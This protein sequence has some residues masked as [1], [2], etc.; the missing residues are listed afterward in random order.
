MHSRKK[1]NSGSTK[2]AQQD[3]PSWVTTKP[4]E[5]EMIITK[6]AKGG[7][8]ASEIGLI[9][10]DS[11]GVPSVKQLL[12]RSITEILSEKKIAP[13]IPEDLM[14][15]IKKSV[16]IRQHIEEN[17]QDQT[18]KRGLMLTES[19]IKRLVRYYKEN[20]VVPMD[21]KYDAKSIRLY[22]E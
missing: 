15:L 10:R 8:T 11:Y 3:V 4:K 22:V 12:G 21:W 18:A 9:L 13:E 19:K 6:L 5:V 1:G 16:K 2:P 14:A 7:K 20:G 17:R